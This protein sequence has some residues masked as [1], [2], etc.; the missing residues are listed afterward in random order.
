MCKCQDCNNENMIILKDQTCRC[1]D[2]DKDK[3]IIIKFN[4]TDVKAVIMRIW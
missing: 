4:C 1:E 3:A 2:C